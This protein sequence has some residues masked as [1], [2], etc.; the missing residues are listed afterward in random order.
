MNSNNGQKTASNPTS[1]NQDQADLLRQ[2]ADMKAEMDNYRTELVELRHHLDTRQETLPGK[3]VEVRQSTSRRRLLKHLATGALGVGALSLATSTAFAETPS[4]IA[5]DAVGGTDGYG[6]RFAGTLAPLRLVPAAGTGKPT[7]ANHKSGELYVD[8]AGSLFYAYGTGG[9]NAN[10]TGWI[11]LAVGG[12]TASSGAQVI[13]NLGTIIDTRSTPPV[14]GIAGPLTTTTSWNLSAIT[15]GAIPTNATSVTG[16]FTLFPTS[17]FVSP[18]A[19]FTF[20]FIY[21]QGSPSSVIAASAN[22]GQYA[23]TG[24]Y[25]SALG[26]GTGLTVQPFSAGTVSVHYAISVISYTV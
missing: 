3:V 2:L 19:A 8:S 17:P 15:G 11:Q 25:V 21:P 23:S 5:V 10:A 4:D 6:G 14:G 13:A 26:T 22:P 20:C 12:A 9:A 24:A 18:F 16:T 7:L 1:S